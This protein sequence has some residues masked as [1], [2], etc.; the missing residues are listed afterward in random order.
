MERQSV[1]INF[2]N[3]YEQVTYRYSNNIHENALYMYWNNTNNDINNLMNHEMSIYKIYDYKNI[4]YNALWVSKL[5]ECVG[6][7]KDDVISFHIEI[8]K[9]G[10]VK[11]VVVDPRYVLNT[12]Q[13]NEDGYLCLPYY[14]IFDE[15]TNVVYIKC[16][17]DYNELL[18]ED[19][20]PYVLK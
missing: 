9:Q 18:D 16:D 14:E 11:F 1:E 20:D 17:C 3:L 12:L 4:K 5:K 19:N 7:K 15:F 10:I 13:I 6:W 2:H 8:L